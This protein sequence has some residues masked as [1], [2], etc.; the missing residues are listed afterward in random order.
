MNLKL[1]GQ[2]MESLRSVLPITGIVLLLAFTIVPIPMGTLGQFICGAMMLIV[3][4]GLFTLGVEMSL[5]PMGS[6]MG[7]FL[8]KKRR[9]WLMV[10]VAFVMGFLITIAE[11]DLAVLAEQVPGVPNMVLVMTVALGVGLLLVVGFLRIVFQKKLS[12]LLIFFYAIVFAV[13]AF[14][15]ENFLPV[16]FDSGGVTTGPITVPFILA[17]GVG[18]AS[19][20]SGRMAQEDSFGLVA[21]GSVG[22]ILAM[23]ILSVFFPSMPQAELAVVSNP[24]DTW[25]LLSEYG[26]AFPHYF[27]E[28]GVALLPILV[29]FFLFQIFA[30]KLRRRQVQRICVGILYTYLG[31]VL[32]LT[33]VNV[34]FLPAGSFIG[35][36]LGGSSYAWVLI[37]MGMVMGY[38]IVAAEPAVHVLNEQVEDLTG[39]AISKR[40]MM[41]SLSIGVALSVGL[42]M[43]RVLTGMSIWWLLIPGY[44][45]AL[46]M[47]FFVPPVFT[48]LAFDSGGVASGAMAT[49]FVLPFAMGAC[50]AL[51]GDIMKDAFGVVAMIAMTPLITIQ[52]LGLIY[53]FKMH[54]MKDADPLAD[55]APPGEDAGDS[56][57]IVD[58]D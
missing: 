18:V 16:A 27:M 25:A 57:Q 29:L 5:T 52:G 6:Q 21:M 36:V 49:T 58:M 33:G 51:G 3:G 47:T 44:A 43:L 11:P 40:A 15:N 7:S 53:R 30:L 46:S 32:F 56:T 12:Y 14:V 1:K 2:I 38:F 4:M 17:L 9:L 41:L 20:R 13:G 10:A 54:Q 42:S 48:A 28:V 35:G 22:P 34:G 23:M 39:G 45:L 24:P 55:G 8:T 26:H 37:P 50:A 19:V 31:L